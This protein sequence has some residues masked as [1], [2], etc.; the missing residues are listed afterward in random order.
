MSK[1]F[2][3][4][5]QNFKEYFVFVSLIVLSLYLITL[6]SSPKIQKLRAAIFG[7]YASLSSI[8]TELFDFRNL[9]SEN[10]N[11]RKTN[12]ELMLQLSKLRQDI[13]L[14]T[15][16]K[17]SLAL[18]DTF[19]YSLISSRI[20]SRQV[21]NHQESF[22][23]DCGKKD[24]VEIGMPVISDKGLVGIVFSVSNNFSLI[25]TLRNSDL[26]LTI[27]SERT[28]E[29]GILKWKENNLRIINVPKTYQ[30]KKGDRI[31]VSEISSI[32]PIVFPVGV[33]YSIENIEKGIFNEIIVHPFIDFD[34]LK[35]VFVVPVVAS[36]EIKDLELNFLKNLR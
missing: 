10:D 7:S 9:K 31:V 1:L 13:L 17:N 25:R 34:K 20:V 33:A 26:S 22:I 32:V 30:I 5:W 18:K 4:F 19:K 21:N 28:G 15:E 24:G 14:I 11:L 2:V 29:Q 35:Y 23:L 8:F 16:L 12:A 6:D 3:H 36:K 27:K